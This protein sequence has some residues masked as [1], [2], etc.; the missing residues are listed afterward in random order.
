MK[1]ASLQIQARGGEL[2]GIGTENKAYYNYFIEIPENAKAINFIFAT[3]VGQI[4]GFEFATQKGFDPDKP[5]NLAKSV[6][7]K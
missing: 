2:L 4:L 7:V 3:I 6:T 5:R 1:N